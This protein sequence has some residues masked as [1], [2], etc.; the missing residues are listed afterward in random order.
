MKNVFFK[1]FVSLAIM[2]FAMNVHG[3]TITGVSEPF[4]FGGSQPVNV[5]VSPLALVVGS[6]L[7]VLFTFW[8][9]YLSRKKGIA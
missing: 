8:R 2:L 3:E 1:K 4:Q 5:P 9:Y 6:L 7:I